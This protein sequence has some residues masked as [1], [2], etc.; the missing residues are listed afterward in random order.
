VF[1]CCFSRHT[2]IDTRCKRGKTSACEAANGFWWLLLLSRGHRVPGANSRQGCTSCCCLS[3][4]LR[5]LRSRQ[6]VK[7]MALSQTPA[8]TAAAAQSLQ[9]GVGL[10]YLDVIWATAML[11]V[12]NR[13]SPPKLGCP[14]I[15]VVLVLLLYHCSAR[16]GESIVMNT[17]GQ[18]QPCRCLDMLDTLHRDTKYLP[19]LRWCKRTHWP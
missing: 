2:T 7:M 11:C 12:P 19:L 4:A 17:F 3:P 18:W 5:M 10:H 9:K 13:G 6:T 1:S 8:G 14:N 15:A 16:T